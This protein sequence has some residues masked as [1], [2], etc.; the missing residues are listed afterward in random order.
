[1]SEQPQEISQNG[2]PNFQRSSQA[3]K[4]VLILGAVLLVLAV[5]ANSSNTIAQNE[6]DAEGAGEGDFKELAVMGG[7]QRKNVSSDFRGG[8]ATA[9]MGGIELDLRDASMER[10]EAVLDISTVMGGVKIRVPETW[11]VVSRVNTVMGGFKDET[12]KPRNEEHRL[13]VKGTLLM[14]GLKVSN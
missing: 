1:M 14:G 9:V 4:P 10:A 3:W 2:S 13:I 6:S 11:T 12:R 7:V 8:E 5:V